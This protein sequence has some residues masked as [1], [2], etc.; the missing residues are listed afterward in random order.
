MPLVIQIGSWF[1]KDRIYSHHITQENYLRLNRLPKAT[2]MNAVAVLMKKFSD[3]EILDLIE[4][5]SIFCFD[6]HGPEFIRKANSGFLI[7]IIRTYVDRYDGQPFTETYLTLGDE[8]L[9]GYQCSAQSAAVFSLLWA[10]ALNKVDSTGDINYVKYL[11]ANIFNGILSVIIIENVTK[12]KKLS[13]LELILLGKKMQ[14]LM[15]KEAL[16]ESFFTPILPPDYL[17]MKLTIS[18]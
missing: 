7:D 10:L 4:R 2:R 3:K 14:D 13:D 5:L 18:I 9:I 1:W 11:P 12:H 16:I 15:S 6:H 8:G 17:R